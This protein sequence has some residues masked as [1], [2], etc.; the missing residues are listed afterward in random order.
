MHTP[1]TRRSQYVLVHGQPEY[2]DLVPDEGEHFHLFY[3][4]GYDLDDNGVRRRVAGIS[5][6]PTIAASESLFQ[7]RRSWNLVRPARCPIAAFASAPSFI[8]RPRAT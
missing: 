5:S 7:P 6:K 8:R 1:S 4:Y 3:S 2:L